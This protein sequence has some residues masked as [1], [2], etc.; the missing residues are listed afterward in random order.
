MTYRDSRAIRGIKPSQKADGGSGLIAMEES[1][2][3]M[4]RSGVLLSS[5]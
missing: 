5:S 4:E 2:M 3:L 1:L